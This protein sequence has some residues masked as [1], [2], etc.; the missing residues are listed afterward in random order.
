MPP[1]AVNDEQSTTSLTN[2]TVSGN[3]AYD[4][5]GGVANYATLS[6]T[7]TIV[8]GNNGGDVVDSAV[9]RPAAIT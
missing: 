2:C 6:L 1:A 9:R 8:A 4:I 3:T 7:N 5:G